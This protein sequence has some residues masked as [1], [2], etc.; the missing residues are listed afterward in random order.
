MIPA[1]KLYVIFASFLMTMNRSVCCGN[2]VPIPLL[3]FAKEMV[4]AN[5]FG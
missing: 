1:N 2:N 3:A 4:V 5:S